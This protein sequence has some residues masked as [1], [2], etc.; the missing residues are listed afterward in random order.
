MFAVKGNKEIK[1][2]EMQKDE[3]KKKGYTIL[4]DSLKVIE[5]P[6]NLLENVRAENEEL[7]EEIKKIKKIKE[8][9]DKIESIAKENKKLKDEIKVLKANAEKQKA[10]TENENGKQE[11]K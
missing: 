2:L 8:D 10:T 7:K 1:I 6:Q 11:N 5:R 4:D 9:N 3:Y